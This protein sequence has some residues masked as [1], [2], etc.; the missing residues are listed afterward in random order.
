[1]V[2]DCDGHLRKRSFPALITHGTIY[3]IALDQVF[4]ALDAARL[5]GWPVTTQEQATHGCVLN[6]PR[7]IQ[8][9]ALTCRSLAKMC[10]D[11]WHIRAQGMFFMFL[12]ASLEFTTDATGQPST[13]LAD[14]TPVSPRQVRDTCATPARHLCSQRSDSS[15]RSHRSTL[16]V[17]VS[18]TDEADA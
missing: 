15:K 16:T 4:T 18:D 1:M 2:V 5:T 10:G 6:S 8:S 9:G 17:S 12:A 13:P 11:G 7:L 3:N 14:P